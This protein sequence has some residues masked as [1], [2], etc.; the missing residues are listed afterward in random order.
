M[1]FLALFIQLSLAQF[2]L[3]IDQI[4]LLSDDFFQRRLGLIVHHASKNR[5]GEHLIDLMNK[6]YPNQ[7]KVL[8]TPE[9]GLRELADDWVEDGI[10]TSGLPYFSL[11]KPDRKAPTCEMLKDIDELV[12][13]LQDVGM[14]FYTFASTMSL[15]MKAASKCGLQN[16]TIL[17]RPNPIGNKIEGLILEPALQNH[18]ISL[19]P[20]TT[21]HGLTMGEMAKYLNHYYKFNLRIRIV[22]VKNL[23]FDAH[24]TWDELGL[25]WTTPSPALPTVGNAKMYSLLGALEAFN[26][27]VGRDLDNSQAFYRFGAPWMKGKEIDF[28]IKLNQLTPH[29]KFYPISWIPGRSR[30]KGEQVWGF[31][32]RENFNY[33]KINGSKL[34]FKIIS[35]LYCEFEQFK[36]FTNKDWVHRYLGQKEVLE[37]LK[38][39]ELKELNKRLNKHKRQFKRISKEFRL[40]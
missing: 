28:V 1:V 10:D 13:D 8:F 12:I 3:G 24:K 4:A 9:H 23:M 19:H 22:T 37:M 16:I 21:R 26:L 39:G 32:V 6:L 29:M 7:V 17:D 11:Y 33:K 36:A 30:Y 18:F 35:M 20:F 14:R 5:K 40:Y 25:K 15:S 31:Q 38:K 34:L 2:Q 27:A